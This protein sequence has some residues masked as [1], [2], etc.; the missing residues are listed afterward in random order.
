MSFLKAFKKNSV[1]TCNHF[2]KQ[3]GYTSNPRGSKGVTTVTTVTTKNSKVQNKIKIKNNEFLAKCRTP[4]GELLLIE[5]DSLEIKE[6]LERFN[7]HLECRSSKFLSTS[8]R[9]R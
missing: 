6:Q 1:T 3:S 9:T 4:A 2:K 7:P 8:S 5:T